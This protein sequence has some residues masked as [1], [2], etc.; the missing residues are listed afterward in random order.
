VTTRVPEPS[1]LLRAV[2][3][4][5]N[6]RCRLCDK[7]L[8]ADS[9]ECRLNHVIPVEQGGPDEY[10]NL[11]LTC[12]KCERERGPRS[13]AEYEEYLYSKNRKSWEAFRRAQGRQQT[14]KIADGYW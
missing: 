4:R 6:G 8:K 10:F 3:E 1:T 2:F 14:S 5:D 11:Q 7:Q 13:N 12:D 9:R